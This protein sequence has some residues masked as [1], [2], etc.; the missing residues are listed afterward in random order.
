MKLLYSLLS[1]LVFNII[2]EMLDF[3]TKHVLLLGAIKLKS[4]KHALYFKILSCLFEKFK[5][6][7]PQDYFCVA[8]RDYLYYFLFKIIFKKKMSFI[9]SIIL[10]IDYNG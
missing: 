5:I 6:L 4:E 8:Q 1:Q 7:F 9:S 3:E 10:W 2:I